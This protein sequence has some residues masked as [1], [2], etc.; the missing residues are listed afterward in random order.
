MK[1]ELIDSKARNGRDTGADIIFLVV[2]VVVAY[3]INQ[4]INQ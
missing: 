3:S 2:V 4:S 1:G